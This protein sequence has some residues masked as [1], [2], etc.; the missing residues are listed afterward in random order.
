MSTKYLCLTIEIIQMR[1]IE[2]ARSAKWIKMM[3]QRDKQFRSDKLR[4]RVYKGKSSCTSVSSLNDQMIRVPFLGIPNQVRGTA[5]CMLLGVSAIKKEQEGT[6]A[7]SSDNRRLILFVTQAG[8][9][10]CGSSRCCT[11]LMHGKLTWTSIGRFE[12][13][14]CSKTV[15]I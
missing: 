1:S 8:T 13:T 12:T 14:K 6:I 9:E 10:K 2:A 15:T 3:D 5:W 7:P 11:L 4:Q